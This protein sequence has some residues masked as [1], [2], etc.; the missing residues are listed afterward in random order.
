MPNNGPDQVLSLD[1]AGRISMKNVSQVDIAPTVARALGIKMPGLDGEP[2][3]EVESWD[4]QNVVLVI[5]DSFGY[6][7]YRMLEPDL[8]FISELASHG[9]L[10]GAEA[11]SNHTSPAIASILSGLLPEHHNIYNT[12]SAKRSK[13]MSFPEIA[14]SSGLRSAVI[15]EK[16]GAEIYEG[17]IDIIGGVP[18]SLSPSDFDRE[19]CRLSLDALAIEPR[20]MVS[21]F[22][23]IDKTTHLGLG[24]DEIKDAALS[25]DHYVGEIAG[26]VAPGTM[27]ILC[28]DHP[29]HAGRFKRRH[30]PYRVALILWK[31]QTSTRRR[32]AQSSVLMKQNNRP[33]S[34]HL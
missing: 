2:I 22:I 18:D 27:M 23:G 10:I 34:P 25:I 30:G 16:N 1:L 15:M 21:Y 32:R 8:R 26:A 7:L 17:L 20:L 33:V 4:C 28:G 14:S 5:I 31:K 11:V 3:E 29:I 6:D 12:E 19:I 24:L 9:I 13:I